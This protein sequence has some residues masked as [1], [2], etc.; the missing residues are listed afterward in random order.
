[1]TRAPTP[2][3]AA[4]I[5]RDGRFLA[6]RRPPEKRHGGRWEFPGGKVHEGE[7]IVA[8][9]ARELAEELA[10]EAVRIGAPLFA[11]H[12]EGA[13]FEIHFVPVEAAGHP[14]PREHT[15][16]GWFTI[17]ELAGMPLAPADARFVEHLA[18]SPE[19]AEDGPQRERADD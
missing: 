13:P 19:I 7:S 16:I 5:T 2:V 9:A 11:A 14:Q 4:V 1:M 3:I 17:S 18:S 15:E 8:A 10:L 12:D 6:G